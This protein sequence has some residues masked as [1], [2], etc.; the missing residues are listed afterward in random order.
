VPEVACSRNRGGGAPSLLLLALVWL[1]ALV[2]ACRPP[3]QPG[4]GAD[5]WQ[6]APAPDL[7]EVVGRVAGVPI[8]AGE[9]QAEMA[10]SGRGP[11]EAFDT[12]TELNLL[13]ERARQAKHTLTLSEVPR[14]LLVQRLLERDFEA[15]TTAAQMPEEDLRRAYDQVRD[16]YVHPRL[17]DVA[18]L[19]VY[20]GPNM[21]P[22][23]R[24]RARQN[25]MALA[26][27]LRRQPRLT[28]E[29]AQTLARL[30]EWKARKV[31]YWRFW[32]GPDRHSGPF[33]GKV[34]PAVTRLSRP[35]ETSGLVEDDSGYHFALYLG[36]RPPS[37]VTFEEAREEVRQKAYPGWRR[38]RFEVLVKRLAQEHTVEVHRDRVLAGSAPAE[39]APVK[40]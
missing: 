20:T 28:A 18:L 9:V 24:A 32:Q 39:N 11:R 7:G 30:P 35:R 19:S 3:R 4:A 15:S 16:Q 13:A 34:A 5:P 23:P 37:N 38:H 10:R 8:F 6:P 17:V 2:P 40:R 25:A 26:E 21:K 27:E 22:E 33:G 14:S 36:E 12:L 31:V 1:S 29:D